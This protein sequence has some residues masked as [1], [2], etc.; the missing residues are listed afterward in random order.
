MLLLASVKAVLVIGGAMLTSGCELLH[1]QYIAKLYRAAVVSVVCV[2]KISIFTAVGARSLVSY[3]V[4]KCLFR[5][6]ARLL[7]DPL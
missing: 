1:D 5:T 3:C 7:Y 6:K 2:T 4:R